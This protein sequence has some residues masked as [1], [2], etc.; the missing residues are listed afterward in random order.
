VDDLDAIRILPDQVDGARE[1]HGVAELLGGTQGDHLAAADDAAVLRAAARGDEHVDHAAG[2]DVEEVQQRH[3]IDV[4]GE[5]GRDQGAPE[6][7]AGL[8]LHVRDEPRL[9][10][11]GVELAG[12]GGVPG[13]VERDRRSQ[14][15]ERRLRLAHVD[16]RLLVEAERLVLPAAGAAVEPEQVVALLVAR[17]RLHAELLG[18][19]EHAVLGRA[20]PLAAEL[21][22]RAV[23]ERVV[24]DAA[25]HAI[26]GLEHE[27][28]AALLLEAAGGGQASEAGPDDDDVKGFHGAFS[29]FQGVNWFRRDRARRPRN[30]ACGRARRPRRSRP[31]RRAARAGR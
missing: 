3:L 10:R 27:D 2:V 4:G 23:G 28:A 30:A 20:D 8:G 12:V 1:P 19:R 9:D 25:T 18:E 14:R 29:L 15:L 31:R 11:L 7:Q 26:A 22:D 13:R 17:K 21:H 6:A 24:E 16:Q 5:D